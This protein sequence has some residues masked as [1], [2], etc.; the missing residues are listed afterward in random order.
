MAFLEEFYLAQDVKRSIIQG[1]RGYQYHPLA[2]ANLLEFLI[3][4]IGFIPETV[5]FVNKDITVFLNPILDKLV[6]FAQRFN[7]KTP[8]TEIS[9]SIMPVINRK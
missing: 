3:S 5:S 9:E 7:F 2:P 6:Q 8:D 1:C 4:L